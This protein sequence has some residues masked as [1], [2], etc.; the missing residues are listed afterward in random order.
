MKEKLHKELAD[1]FK[2]QLASLTLEMFAGVLL[3]ISLDKI[4]LI[5]SILILLPG[6]ME[7]RGNISGTMSARI[8]SGLILGEVKPK[9]RKNKIL[10]GNVLASFILVV[11]D[12][13]ILGVVAWAIT[14]FIFG[15]SSMTVIWIALAAG[16]LS[17]ALQVPIVTYMTFWF[18]KKGHDPNDVM[19]PYITAI[20]DLLSTFSLFLLVIVV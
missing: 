8:S 19:G 15:V 10:K 1:I 6:F 9:W 20:G 13:L 7:M 16:I 5:P 18:F 4:L 17:N 11:V 12:S 3:A 2:S 14:L